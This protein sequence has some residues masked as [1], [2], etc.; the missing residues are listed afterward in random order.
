MRPSVVRQLVR[1][2][3][4]VRLAVAVLV[5]RSVSFAGRCAL[6]SAPVIAVSAAP[7][8]RRSA[9]LP[10]SPPANDFGPLVRRYGPSLFR[11]KSTN[12]LQPRRSR[13]RRSSGPAGRAGRC[14]TAR[15]RRRGRRRAGTRPAGRL[16]LVSS[17]PASHGT[18]ELVQSGVTT[19]SSIVAVAAAVQVQDQVGAVGAG[20][21]PLKPRTGAVEDERLELLRDLPGLRDV[22][23]V[24]VRRVVDRRR[25]LL[26]EVRER[27]HDLVVEGADDV[28]AR[29]ERVADQRDADALGGAVELRSSLLSS[30][31]RTWT[32]DP[33]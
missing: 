21:S 19:T 30:C 1:I 28:R 2:D 4:A 14:R 3:A 16:M 9:G 25:D 5:V 24:A 12:V 15:P 17:W 29:V 11:P 7:R 26:R 20:P 32:A 10:V 6:F 8:R 13:R 22:V 27:R 33:S 18:Y 31:G 23:V